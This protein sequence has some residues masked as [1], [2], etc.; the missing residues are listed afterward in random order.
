MLLRVGSKSRRVVVRPFPQ[1]RL[2]GSLAELEVDPAGSGFLSIEGEALTRFILSFSCSSRIAGEISIASH[3]SSCNS[4]HTSQRWQ[5]LKFYRDSTIKSVQML[6]SYFTGSI[7]DG[8]QRFW[9]PVAPVCATSSKLLCQRWGTVSVTA[10]SC[11]CN[12]CK[13]SGT[14]SV[15]RWCFSCLLFFVSP[16]C[17][18]LLPR[19]A[20]PSNGPLVAVDAYSSSFSLSV[21]SIVYSTK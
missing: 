5:T 21:S 13:A 12:L 14:L 6:K 1:V 9:S 10:L 20:A 7:N 15:S 11:G 8:K 4:S 18:D 17:L 3:D 2:S 16:P 19:C